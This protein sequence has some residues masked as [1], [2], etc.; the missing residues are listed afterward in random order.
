MKRTLIV[1]PLLLPLML[2]SSHLAIAHPCDG[3]VAVRADKLMRLHYDDSG[4]DLQFSLDDG[5]QELASIKALKGKGRFDVL[6][7]NAYVNK[8]TY[9]MHFIY[10]QIADSCLLMGQEIIEVSDPY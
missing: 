5:P 6:E 7:I 9:R 4:N 3:D 2:A 10:A 1:L 8:A